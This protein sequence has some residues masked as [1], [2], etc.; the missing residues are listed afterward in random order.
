MTTSMSVGRRTVPASGPGP[1]V[2]IDSDIL[3]TY[4]LCRRP[5]VPLGRRPNRGHLGGRSIV[6]L[7]R[8]R[9]P[10]AK[11]QSI[12]G[13]RALWGVTNAVASVKQC[14]PFM[15]HGIQGG[16]VGNIVETTAD[17]QPLAAI[18]GKGAEAEISVCGR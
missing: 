18:A 2:S 11:V 9:H 1:V 8:F 4:Q 16:V 10:G 5:I 13:G 3:L 17:R 15:D 7:P 12:V 6:K 14:I